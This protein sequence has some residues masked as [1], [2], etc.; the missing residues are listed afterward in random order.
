MCERERERERERGERESGVNECEYHCV[1]E[2][3]VKMTIMDIPTL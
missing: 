1:R 3:A 2:K